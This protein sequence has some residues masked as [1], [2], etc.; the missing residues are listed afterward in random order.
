MFCHPTLRGKPAPKREPQVSLT[1]SQSRLS[2]SI[3][4]VKGG[5]T[6]QIHDQKPAQSSFFLWQP[7][8]V[9]P[10]GFF[11]SD[12][13][14]FERQVR[15]SQAGGKNM[16]RLMRLVKW[17]WH[18]EGLLWEVVIHHDF[19]MTQSSTLLLGVMIRDPWL[20]WIVCV[21][22]GGVRQTEC[23]YVLKRSNQAGR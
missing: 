10:G 20:M 22:D 7:S 3:L 8:Y 2:S 5:K 9:S 17:C 18:A 4:L 13:R 1:S 6:I 14:G 12:A 19:R 21:S 15:R 11:Q 16:G 23:V